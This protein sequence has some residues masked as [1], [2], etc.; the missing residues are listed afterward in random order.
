[1]FQTPLITQVVDLER[2]IE[3]DEERRQNHRSEPYV[4]Y[5]AKVQTTCRTERESILSRVLRLFRNR[6]PP[7][8]S[9]TPNPCRDIQ[10]G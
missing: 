6:Q 8:R 1:M 4:N 9:Y 2:R 3:I 5:L 7:E 10:P